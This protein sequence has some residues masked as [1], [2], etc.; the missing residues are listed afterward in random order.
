MA[1]AAVLGYYAYTVTFTVETK[2]FRA[3]FDET[4]RSFQTSLAGSVR[5]S[6]EA[7][8]AVETQFS[9]AG[10][11]AAHPTF[12]T[13]CAHETVTAS[14]MGFGIGPFLRS[15]DDVDRFARFVAANVALSADALR[16]V[17]RTI[18][19]TNRTMA[20][21]AEV[22]PFNAYGAY[23]MFDIST[24]VPRAFHAVDAGAEWA[25]SEVNVLDGKAVS[26]VVTAVRAANDTAPVGFT[27]AL[28]DW[29]VFMRHA[30]TESTGGVYAVLD[31]ANKTFTFRAHPAGGVEFVGE[32]D[33]HVS[34][35][36]S[37]SFA[38]D[39]GVPA[40]NTT[41]HMWAVGAPSDAMAHRL[42]AGVIGITG[43]VA[44]VFVV[45]DCISGHRIRKL[46]E[47][48]ARVFVQNELMEVNALAEDA[49]NKEVFIATISHEIRT[50]LNAISGAVAL[51]RDTEMNAE[52]RE[53]IDMLDAGSSHVI[54]VVED[55][56]SMSHVD[57]EQFAVAPEPCDPMG[58]IV[59]PA[60]NMVIL[61]Q[62]MHDRIR[63]LRLTRT[64]ATNIPHRM[65]LDAGRVTQIIINMMNNAIKFTPAGGEVELA[66]SYN[67]PTRGKPMLNI[68]MRDTG[69]GIAPEDI[70]RIFGAFVQTDR[71]RTEQSLQGV[72]L[73]LA[74]SR[75]IA[76]KMDGDL[77]CT[78]AGLG[79]G[80]T[81]TLIVPSSASAPARTRSS[82]QRGSR[83]SGSMVASPTRRRSTEGSTVRSIP[84][85]SSV[86]SVMSV[87]VADD[88]P[89]SRVIM[90]KVLEKS[91]FVVF[92]VSNG[93]ELVQEF[94]RG[95]YD[96]VVTDL[97]MPVK[98][99]RE[100]VVEILASGATA[101]I[102]IVSAS[103]SDEEKQKSMSAGA[104]AHLSKPVGQDTI[105][106]LHALLGKANAAARASVEMLNY[107]I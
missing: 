7:C 57:S 80:S 60:W 81:F 88:D 93:E 55:V 12:E 52:Q 102:I 78:S 79:R 32:G 45:Y 47:E 50:P 107:E 92:A 42:L 66:V 53:L 62:R 16:A 91:G 36:P 15:S 69:V 99:G 63:L 76:R 33:L 101:P 29:T 96:A 18:E 43:G 64:E 86:A 51:L 82:I 19:G 54:L 35:T 20:V 100:A 9:F 3:R 48:H 25:V 106:T 2:N 49:R 56:L 13:F 65:V 14:V 23:F 59:T 95:T 72:G 26:L 103:V 94:F 11:W 10:E 75:R 39:T 71:E 37:S 84:S 34:E 67:A 97:Q 87:L 104:L 41:V 73:G 1:F 40:W 6:T 83:I 70:E 90:T 4:V 28:V 30:A 17:P 27:A 8:R 105:R 89:I 38:L 74:I 31:H 58:D 5:R 44:A 85:I 21:V 61:N 46:H 77:T 24:I 98:T 22:A 68:S